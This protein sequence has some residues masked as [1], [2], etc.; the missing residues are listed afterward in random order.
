MRFQAQL[1]GFARQWLGAL[2]FV[3]TLVLTLAPGSA[4]AQNE[5]FVAN[6]ETPSVT[7]Y[8][9]TASGDVAPL[10]T[11]T[12]AS[13]TFV[14]PTAVVVDTAHNEMFVLDIRAVDV[15]PINANGDVAPIRRISGAN[16]AFTLA[17]GLAYDPVNDELYVVDQSNET[18]SVFPRTANGNVAPTRLLTGAATGLVAPFG[19]AVD[20][21]HNEIAITN[22]P[23]PFSGLT[24]SVTVYPRTA[25][26]NAVP[27]RTL[28]G[29]STGLNVPEG[30]FI[31]TTHDEM[32]LVDHQTSAIFVYSSTASGNTFPIRSIAGSSTGLDQPHAITLD[33]ASNEL[34]VANE[35]GN[36]IT[37]YGRLFSGDVSPARTLGG[38]TSG[39]AVPTGVAV[40]PGGGGGPTAPA[41]TN[42]PPPNG[43]VGTPYSFTYTA[44]GTAP[45]TFSVTSG[46]LPPGLN[47]GPTGNIV[48][49]PTTPGTFAGVVTATN[50]TAPDATQP[51]SIVIAAAPVI[52]APSKPIPTLSTW[53]LWILGF[54]LAVL[55][56]SR[57]RRRAS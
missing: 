6:S 43:T 14:G 11:I 44:T 32:L 26:G 28:A 10:R 7:V 35:R 50:G 21:V 25:S 33:L 37:V 57:L 12:G 34:T 49:G 17:T 46:A 51:F 27:L 15:F 8:T 36:T 23:S 13:T 31:D 52:V 24:A 20:T 16:P 30:I 40:T 48:G 45:I 39:V 41:I 38:P 19:V 29:G 53:G 2:G 3:A 18:V 4:A 54:G 42:G 9:R 1:V 47:L 22:A 55:A 56:A 5:L